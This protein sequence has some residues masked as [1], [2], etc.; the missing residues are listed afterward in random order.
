[1]LWSTRR[2]RSVVWLSGCSLQC[3]GG[4]RHVAPCSQ[5]FAD[6]RGIAFLE[7]SAKNATNVERAFVTMA[8]EIK[9]KCGWGIPRGHAVVF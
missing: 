6:E 3:V 5:A 1:V 2:P 8:S 9:S 7:T 4:T